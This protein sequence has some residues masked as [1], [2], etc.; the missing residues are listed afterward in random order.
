M[1]LNVITRVSADTGIDLIQSRQ[2][3]VDYYNA[4]S[5]I[6]HS[7]LEANKMF[8]E[9]TLV[10]PPDSVVSLPA[11]VGEIRGIRVHTTEMIVP[12]QSLNVPRYTNSTLLYKI[13]NWRDLGESPV[14]TNLTTIGP[15]T[16]TVPAVESTPAILKIRGQ[17]NAAESIEENITISA[18][19]V[20][21]T[22][23]FGPKIFN[24]ASF[25]NRQNNITISDING[26]VLATLLNN[27]LKTR[28]KIIDVSQIFWPASDTVGGSS[29]IDVLY[30]VP[31][32][33]CYNDTDSFAGGDDYDEALY[34]MMLHLNFLAM[35]GKDQQA[36][37]E[38]GRATQLL[39]AVKD[40]AEQ[41]IHK[42]LNWGRNKYYGI[43]TRG[44]HRMSG[45]DYGMYFADLVDY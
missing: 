7:E 21:T 4:A 36:A 42:K 18:T 6:F 40:G 41:G 29:F 26:N 25:S 22:N 16:I 38:L 31:F 30:K 45:N 35:G 13:K 44:R 8:R 24:V 3:L 28:Y 19:T 10:V 12:L 14:Q 23:Q 1:L 33:P 32:Q 5:R 43:F 15:L 11:F 27:Q 9:T 34:H 2:S 37:A 17:T 20:T 39:K